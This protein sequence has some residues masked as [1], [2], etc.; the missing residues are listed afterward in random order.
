M[1]QFEECTWLTKFVSKTHSPEGR[2]SR[3]MTEAER[4]GLPRQ[5]RSGEL[6]GRCLIAAVLIV[7]P[8]FPAVRAAEPATLTSLE[9]AHALSN[10]EASKGIP[11][12]FGATVVYSR[13]YERLLFV[14]DGDSALFVRAP[15]AGVLVPGDRILIR[16]VTQQ[17]FRPIVIANAVTLLRHGG[18]PRPVLADFGELIRAQHDCQLVTVHATVRAADLVMSATAPIRSARLQLLM[19]GGHIEANVDSEDK[20]AL[21]NLL[22]ADVEITGAAA[23]KFDNK[24]QQTGVVLYVSKLADV[25]ILKRSVDSPWSLPVTPMD[26]ILAGYS[27]R[28]LTQ[29]VRVHGAITYY[30]PGSAVVLQDGSR[31]LWISTH[32]REPLQ[33]GDDADATGFP[34][35]HDRV[36]TLAD[37]E[38]LDS[39]I[40]APIT[41]QAATWEQLA[42]WN[43]SKPDGHQND[44]VSIEGQVVTEVRE[45][46]Q[47]EYVVNSDG[48]LFTAIY[49]HPH[50]A[51][52]L[53]PMRQIPLGSRVRFTGV[54]TIL[55]TNAITPG[56][57]VP[58]NI[59]MRSFDDLLVVAGPSMVSIRNL[60]LIVG[61]LLAVLF[62]VGARSWALD[63]KVRRQTAVM[64]ARVE[65]EASLE[66]QRGIIL[67][68]INGSLPLAE[69]IE[70]ITDLVSFQLEGA[71]CWCQITDG[72]Q[73][74]DC[75]PQA[76][77]LR[78]VAAAIPARSGPAL[79]AILVGFDPQKSAV[80]GEAEALS[81]GTRLATLA[82][83]TRRLYSDLQHRAE[84]D[85]LT[86]IHNRFSLERYLDAQIEMAREEAGIFGLIY[87]DLDEFKQVNDG[88]GHQAGDLY[89][90]EA[91]LRMKRQLRPH[92]ML[93]RLGG[94]EFAV[95]ASGVRSRTEVEEVARRLERSF[96]DLYAVDGYVLQGSASV[97]IALYPED[98][99][100]GD[101]LLSAA[102]AA[103][104]VAKQ[105]RRQVDELIS[106]QPDPALTSRDRA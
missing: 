95:L 97:G 81:V 92:D 32:T 77:A 66:R 45:A 24:M 100:T 56:E 55:D 98:G 104:Y 29:R 78:I 47:D 39:N 14:Q 76:Y 31:S 53:P 21:K 51:A 71:P 36:L 40:L 94:D 33:I 73:L 86:E 57:E 37:G 17:S 89:L 5:R 52:V 79:G 27:V 93:A 63:R 64:A 8:S 87:V 6:L 88:Y 18:L 3:G 85:L 82:I 50:G 25:K 2:E 60:L 67:E 102:D 103:M 34:D 69:I 30:Q 65:T 106:E 61:L 22:D 74:G 84:F 9:A 42:F 10:A 23:G 54:C 96:D 4:T 99:T 41:P 1:E 70:R 75:P 38:I 68:D 11:V 28:D 91:A 13:R 49:R 46:T 20:A 12:V 101:S 80:A 44:L 62:A 26:Q 7:G 58:F 90:K 83:E 72:A 59:L 105:T 35:A 16:G 19:E 48:R 43:S 15:T